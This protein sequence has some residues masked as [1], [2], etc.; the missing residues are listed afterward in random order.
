MYDTIWLFEILNEI[1][2]WSI[3]WEGARVWARRALDAN[4]RRYVYVIQ[5]VYSDMHTFTHTQTQNA[6]MPAIAKMSGGGQLAAVACV[7][8]FRRGHTPRAPTH[9]KCAHMN[10]GWSRTRR[11][12]TTRPSNA[13]ICERCWL[14]MYWTRHHRTARTNVI[15][16]IV[17]VHSSV[18][19]CAIWFVKLFICTYSY[20]CVYSNVLCVAY[21]PCAHTIYSDNKE[22][23]THGKRNEKKHVVHNHWTHTFLWTHLQIVFF[24][25]T[26]THTRIHISIAWRIRIIIDLTTTQTYT[27][28]HKSWHSRSRSLYINH[29]PLKQHL[30][31]EHTHTHDI[32]DMTR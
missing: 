21:W 8:V 14:N 27:Y 4:A 17:R 28:T 30:P 13:I 24:T 12:R 16:Q 9:G 10:N 15:Q 19:H 5:R 11:A 23:Y 32:H 1:I 2:L 22:D 7:G 31:A 6:A 20:L 26:H 25:H 29:I 18:K 3:F